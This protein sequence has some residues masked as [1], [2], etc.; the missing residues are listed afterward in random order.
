LAQAQQM[1]IVKLYNQAQIAGEMGYLDDA[2]AKYK[3]I[4]EI[5]PNFAKGYLELGNIYLKKGQDVNSLENAIRYYTEYLRINPDAEDAAAVKASLDKLE[6]V[7]EKSS[8]KEV[9]KEFLQGRWASTDGKTNKYGT[10]ALI[11][12]IQE[13][14]GKIK[15]DIEP[16]SLVY[17]E[18]FTHKTAYIDDPNADQYVITFTNDNTYVPSQAGYAFNSQIISGASYNAFGGSGLGGTVDAVGQYLNSKKQE[19]DV[20]KKTLTVYELKINPVPNENNELKCT[21]RIYIKEITP[22]KEQVILDNVFV[23]GFYKVG[24]HYV[25]TSPVFEKFILKLDPLVR[26]YI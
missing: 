8:Q 14:D 24:N 23:T 21:G 12:D 20:H 15:I 18:D 11:L 9:A 3:Q 22:T 1:D 7:L 16:S 26:V 2:I 19:K 6:F 13:F 25:N 4:L 17:S 10:S 5:N